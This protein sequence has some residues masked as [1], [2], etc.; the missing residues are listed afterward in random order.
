[1]RISK[2]LTMALL[3]TGILSAADPHPIPAPYKD[4]PPT[5]FECRWAEGAI[6]LDGVADESAWKNAQTI[7]AF[8]VPWLKT[9]GRMARTSTKAKLLWDREFLYFFAEMEDTDLFADVTE[10]DGQTWDNDVFELFFK[11]A[12]DKNGYYEFQVNAAGTV[13]DAF[14]PK[15]N[16]ETVTAQKKL[17]TFHIDAKRKL[18]GTLNKRDDVDQGWSVEG[19]IPWTDFL[20]TG[21]RPDL[22]ETWA[23]N[24][25][26]YDYHKDWPKPELS[27]VAPVKVPKVGAHF[28][29]YEDYATLKFVGSKT[30]TTPVLME[31]VPLTTS[32]VVGWPEPPLYRT[33]RIYPNYR[34]DAPV[35]IAHVPGTDQMMLLNQPKAKTP[36]VLWRFK[37]D[38]A[39]AE[40]DVVKVLE[41]PDG[42]LATDFTF[43][44]KFR[45]NGYVYIGWNSK[46][47]NLTDEP[48][49]GSG[50]MNRITRYTMK[51]TPPYDFDPAS[52]KTIIEWES[53]GHNGLAVCF[54]HDGMLY[55]TTGDGTSDSDTNV[56]GQRIDLLL[57]KVLRLDVDH[58]DKGRM[59]S[60]PKDNPFVNDSRYRPETWAYGMRNPWRITCD[61]KTGRIWV[62]SNGQDLWEYAHLLKKGANYGWSVT[63]GSHPFYSQ[64]KLGPDPVT[65]PE[66]EHGHA[67]FRSLTGG[68]VYHGAKLP[69]LQGAYIY[70]DYATGRIWGMKHDGTKVEW[71]KELAISTHKLTCFAL[72]GAGE[73]VICDHAKDAEGG[74]YTLVPMPKDDK[75]NIF[76]RKLSD[77]GLFDSVK[78]HKVKPSVLPYSVNS[79]FWSD[80]MHKERFLAIPAGEKIDFTRGGRSWN[81]PEKTV[82]IKSFA[83]EQKEGD[84]SSRKWIETRFMTKQQGE[85]FGYSY[86][87]NE[88]GTDANLVE[89]KGLDR[90]FT[91]KTAT[92]E[93]KQMWRYPSRGE[94]MVCHSRAANYVLGL[95]EVQ[96]NRDQDYGGCVENQIHALDRLGYLKGVNWTVFAREAASDADKANGQQLNQ[97]M[98]TADR[99][100]SLPGVMKKIANAYDPKETLDAR[101]RAWMHVNCATCHVDAGGG[102]AQIT[103]RFDTAEDK[104]KVFDEKPVHQ[105]FDLPDAKIIAPGHPERSVL[106]HR[107]GLRGPG[108]MPPLAT[109]RVD[110]EALAMMRE[111]VKSLKKP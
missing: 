107:I 11:P 2:S 86:V 84:P 108:Q 92:G 25:C 10:H 103:L 102:N 105:S 78:D 32:T 43:H 76:P 40:K 47:P 35:A 96:M 110:E 55:V 56:T 60:V 37:D 69:G 74:F 109:S 72:N 34:P 80:G 12:E 98:M 79:P 27:C 9:G 90:E 68:V 4:A 30:A 106:I 36:T 70:G 15:R 58:P 54:G 45:E 5:A 82:L 24:L 16:F 57:A 62:G 77:S 41:T 49:K 26:R 44:P 8:H 51:P 63:E 20:R 93:R 31:R 64:R 21:G 59:Y 61:S 100:V 94:C 28:H 65:P 91:I 7:D 29:Q 14:F 39:V 38:P 83:V 53:N 22:G 18:V 48:G 104:M 88:A 6:V 33:E 75:P 3:L 111:W 1:M 101:A 50:K 97:R 23:M 95:S 85:W 99:V 46:I 67:E 19:R 71:H 87:W 42:G 66:I 13:F 52:A 81:F 17:G 73:L 89:A